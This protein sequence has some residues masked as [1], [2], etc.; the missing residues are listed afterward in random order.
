L[1]PTRVQ[2]HSIFGLVHVFCI[3]S[4]AVGGGNGVGLYWL[5]P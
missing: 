5:I 2:Y 3:N 1:P 4:F